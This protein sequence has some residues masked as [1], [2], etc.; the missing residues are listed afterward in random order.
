MRKKMELH[1]K[2][3]KVFGLA[4][5]CVLAVA[6]SLGITACGNNDKQVIQEDLEDVLDTFKNPTV[7][8]IKK[9]VVKA[10]AT[11]DEIEYLD[12]S[13]G[14]IAQIGID[15]DDLFHYLF[16]DF[17]YKIED[18]EVN[19]DTATAKLSITTKDFEAA[20]KSF[21]TELSSDSI[22][23]EMTKMYAQSGNDTTVLYKFIFEKLYA[24]LEKADSKAQDITVDLKK[25]SKGSWYF[26]DKSMNDF[27]N[28]LFGGMNEMGT[29]LQ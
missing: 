6:I 26:E 20:T 12:S 25:S 15:P 8:S 14:A 29:A 27:N 21:Q 7:K 11:K 28:A 16:L 13:F 10:G 24:C 9:A 22:K 4:C 17:D 23:D 18:I 5:A 1:S 2:I 19:G 3:Q